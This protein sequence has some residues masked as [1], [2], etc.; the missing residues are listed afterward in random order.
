MVVLAV[1][2]VAVSQFFG[3][4]DARA[5]E[6]AAAVARGLSCTQTDKAN[7]GFVL[8]C[9]PA[10]GSPSPSTTPSPTTSSPTSTPTPSASSSA[11]ASPSPS[12][13]SPSPTP[14]ATQTGPLTNCQPNPGRCGYPDAISTG[15]SSAA[16]GTVLNGNRTYSTAG[17]QVVNTTINGC[18]E[19]RAANVVFRNVKFNGAGCFYAIRNFATGLAVLDSDIT[20]G[21]A[22]GTGVTS[23]NYAL[24]RVHIYGCE[25]GLNV[26]GN[27]SIVD[28]LIN[29]GVTANGAHTDGIQIN[30]GAT[31]ITVRH[32]TIITPA[33]GGTSAII[34]WDEGN[35]QQQ[36]VEIRGNLLAGGT[37][38]LYCPRQGPSDTRVIDNRFG[39]HQY[40]SANGCVSDHVS[41]WSGNVYDS[42]GL[43]IGASDR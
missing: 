14:T 28:S 38:T 15:S 17:Q 2:F 13:S 1:F 5:A 22:N 27:V 16:G 34:S 32:N 41:A 4:R 10:G 20:C 35:P 7:G 6:L 26:S 30:P 43:P 24:T 12:Q 8:D 33:P 11:T 19:V 39:D 40:G 42:T 21:G 18:V 23:A 36:N 29:Q 9:D 37:Y 31:N 25:N 3:A